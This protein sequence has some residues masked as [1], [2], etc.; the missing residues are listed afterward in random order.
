MVAGNHGLKADRDAIASAS[1]VAARV[2]G[3]DR[4]FSIDGQIPAYGD[5]IRP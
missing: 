1:R 2:V 3:S 4:R 5:R